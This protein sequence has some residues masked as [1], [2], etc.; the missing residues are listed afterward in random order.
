MPQPWW[1]QRTLSK[2]IV[3]KENQF[4]LKNFA[5]LNYRQSFPLRQTHSGPAPTV[6]LRE[7]SALEG[8]QS[9]CLK[10]GRDQLH[11]SALEVSA[12]TRCP[13]RGSWLYHIIYTN[14]GKMDR[15]QGNNKWPTTIIQCQLQNVTLCSIEG[16]MEV[17]FHCR[18][19]GADFAFHHGFCSLSH[20]LNVHKLHSWN[21]I[22]TISLT[23][24]QRKNIK[25]V[26]V[27]WLLS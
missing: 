2:P 4:S 24:E 14:L 12:L 13:L 18:L 22:Y 21:I 10:Y 15:F 16:Y 11:V 3:R 8:D 25:E 23:E 6:S 7:V 5:C 9:K 20:P 26:H 27:W 1:P 17:F 19:V